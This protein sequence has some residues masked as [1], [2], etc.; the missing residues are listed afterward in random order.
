MADQAPTSSS[1]AA[2]E[3]G[4]EGDE[5]FIFGAA[6]G[7]VEARTSCDHLASLSPDLLH[8]PDPD[9]PCNR[10]G[11]HHSL[12]DLLDLPEIHHAWDDLPVRPFLMAYTLGTTPA[13]REIL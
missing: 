2:L 10:R 12:K 9:T 8:I 1:S 11:L 7:W 3:F 5:D 4:T 13:T 6:S